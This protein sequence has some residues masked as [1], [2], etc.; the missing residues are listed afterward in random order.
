MEQTSENSRL[1]DKFRVLMAVVLHV[2][3]VVAELSI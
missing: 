1:K 2:V 3:V